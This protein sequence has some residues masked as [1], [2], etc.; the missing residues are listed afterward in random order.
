M[1]SDLLVGIGGS[2]L[3]SARLVLQAGD[4]LSLVVAESKRAGDE[5]VQQG[6]EVAVGDTPFPSI[7]QGK[8]ISREDKVIRSIFLVLIY[9]FTNLSPTRH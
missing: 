1:V 3:D 4:G 6:D 9:P 7:L 2:V 5:T 8:E